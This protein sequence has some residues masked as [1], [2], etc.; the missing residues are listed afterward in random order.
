MTIICTIC[1][2]GGSKGVPRKNVRMIAGAPLIVHT[3]RHAIAMNRFNQ[4]AVSSDDQAVLDIAETNGATMTVLRPAELSRDE[5]DKLTAIRHCV[6]FV[7]AQIG[8]VNI[9]V[10]L[11]VTAPLRTVGDITSAIR[12]LEESQCDNVITA[13]RAR[14]SPYFNMIEKQ[15]DDSIDLVKRTPM[16]VV[17]RQDSPEVF[18]MN[19]SIYVWRRDALFN[20]ETVIHQGTR[21]LEMPPER[22]LDIDSELDFQVVEF[23]LN[24]RGSH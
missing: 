3:L 12:L 11:D 22:S 14:R 10:D 13:T 21:M 9:V 8:K 24:Q 15:A 6:N 4:I 2:R 5:S 20:R 7:E 19:A 18:D 1:A 16:Q 23:L 17:R